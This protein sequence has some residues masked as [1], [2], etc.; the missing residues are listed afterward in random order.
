MMVTLSA[1]PAPVTLAETLAPFTVGAPTFTSLPSS[2]MTRRAS[3]ESSS[4]SLASSFSTRRTSPSLTRYCLPPVVITARCAIRA[5]NEII[6][7]F[8]ESAVTLPGL[9]A[10]VNMRGHGHAR[11]EPVPPGKAGRHFQHAIDGDP[12]KIHR[13]F[14]ARRRRGHVRRHVRDDVVLDPQ[15]VDGET[16]VLHP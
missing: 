15:D 5:V 10:L 8:R 1:L 13:Q 2:F 7:W 12:R 4:P 11:S 9:P 16:H 6:A 3:N 14:V